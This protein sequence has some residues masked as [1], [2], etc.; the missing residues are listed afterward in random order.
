MDFF[1]TL[2][3]YVN[4]EPRQ[5]VR[6]STRTKAL[7]HGLALDCEFV[8]SI[9]SSNG[10]KKVSKRNS[11][12]Y[13]PVLLKQLANKKPPPIPRIEDDATTKITVL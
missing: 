4:G 7:V 1:F 11:I 8:L 9:E 13:N 3:I 2:Q 6:S 5:N 10:D 12:S